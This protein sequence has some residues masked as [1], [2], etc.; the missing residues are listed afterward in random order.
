M[1]LYCTITGADDDVDPADLVELSKK[2]PFVEWG[3]LFYRKGDEF[4]HKPR[5]PTYQWVSR[6]LE[7][8][9]SKPVRKSVHLC[10]DYVAD[11]LRGEPIYNLNKFDRIQLNFKADA[12]FSDTQT[13]FF[14]ALVNTSIKKT[15]QHVIT[16]YNA[17]NVDLH[18]CMGF[19]KN[20]DVLFDA[21][22]GKGIK[23]MDWP[24]PV[25]ASRCGYAGGLGADNLAVEM[26][27]IA[28]VAGCADYWVDME[29][30]V[31][32]DNKFDLEKVERALETVKLY[33]SR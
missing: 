27:R 16:Q 2:Y 31:R 11:F 14:S 3:I 23:A 19:V 17:E 6:F 21:S 4:V 30:G 25:V 8:T 28:A 33:A 20:H 32:T 12:E 10:G 18:R 1:L 9:E 7:A 24:K 13:R 5:Y 22:G 15:L 26:P 29:T